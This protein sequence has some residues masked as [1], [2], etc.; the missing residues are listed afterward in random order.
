MPP[1]SRAAL[2]AS[3]GS[4]SQGQPRHHSPYAQQKTAP[5]RLSQHS[6][7]PIP[8]DSLEIDEWVVR[9]RR[10]WHYCYL[11]IAVSRLT[12]QVLAFVVGARS[13][14]RR[15]TV[16]SRVPPAYRRQLIYTDAYEVYAAFF[17]RW[18]HRPSP[19]RSG[20]TSVAE[21]LHNTWRNRLAALVRRTVYLRDKADLVRR[22]R[23]VFDQ[24]N[25][26][27]RRIEHL[28][29]HKLATP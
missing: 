4:C 20:R 19:E 21:G 12:R 15:R 29:W 7:P 10:R 13:R 14:K 1:L 9:Y 11:W 17:R 23:L 27:C 24:H 26:L 8:G 6:L 3:G 25:R 18:Q 16:W 28:G 2:P 5:L 22:L